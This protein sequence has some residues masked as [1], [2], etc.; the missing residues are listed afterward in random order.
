VLLLDK[1]GTITMAIAAA[2]FIPAPGVEEKDL[3]NCATGFDG[4]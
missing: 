4:R 3:A 1:T 2:A